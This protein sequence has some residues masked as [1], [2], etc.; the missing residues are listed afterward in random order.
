MGDKIKQDASKAIQ[1]AI[2]QINKAQYDTGE[3]TV[4]GTSA[5]LLAGIQVRLESAMQTL[6]SIKINQNDEANENGTEGKS[7]RLP[8]K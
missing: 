7:R 6:K 1:D 8:E 5:Q 3:L 4:K 2:S